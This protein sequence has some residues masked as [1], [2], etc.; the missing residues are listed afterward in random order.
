M[1]QT[2]QFATETTI[3][4]T[5][6]DSNGCTGTASTEITEEPSLSPS[7]LGDLIICEGQSTILDAGSAFDTW[8]WSTGEMT[9]T[10]EVSDAGVYSVFVTQGACSG[11]GEV[12]VIVNPLPSPS[13][14]GPTEICVGDIGTLEVLETFSIYSWSTNS[15]LQSIIVSDP[16]LYTVTVTDINGCSGTSSYEVMEVPLPTPEI[17]GDPNFCPNES[18]I[19]ELSESYE[20]YEW[21][22]GSDDE[23]ISVSMTGQYTVTVTDI[24]GCSGN[25]AINVF[26][27]PEVT[28]SIGGS[29]TYCPGGN[30]TLDGGSQYISWLWN[31][32][33]TTQT[34]QFAMEETVTLEVTDINGCV[35]TASVNITEEPSLSPTILGD[36]DICEG[37]TTI[38]DGGAAFDT[39]EWSTGETTQ[40]IEVNTSGVYTLFV[41]QGTCSGSG[42]I[43]VTVNPLPNAEIEGN[44]TICID[45]IGNLMVTDNFEQYSWSTGASL[46]SV[47]ISDPGIYTVTVTDINGCTN[48]SS[49]EVLEVSLPTP[50][51]DGDPNFCIDGSTTLGLT[52]AFAAYNWSTGST[53]AMIDVNTTGQYMVT[54]TDINGCEGSTSVNVFTYPEVEPIIGGSTSYCPGG[55]TTLDGGSQYIAWEWSTGETTQTIEFNQEATVSLQV[56]DINGCTG[57]SSVEITE[58]DSLSPS[59]I[60]DL[61]ICEGESTILD[62]GAAFDTWEWST[63]ETTQTI[64]VT[65]SGT[66]SLEVTQGACSGEGEV[67]VIV[68]PLPDPL[69]DGP[70]SICYGEDATLTSINEYEA[71][72]WTTG[73]ITRSVDI[74]NP[75]SYSLIVTDENGCTAA[76]N[77]EVIAKPTPILTDIIAICGEDKD[78]YDVTFST[79]ADEVSCDTYPVESLGTFDYAVNAI[80]TN[81]VIQIYLLDTESMCDTTITIEK[82]NCSCSAIADA[83][84]DGE[85]NCLIEQIVLGG[86]NTSEGPSFTYEWRDEDG[87]LVSTDAQYTATE[88]GTY[89]LEVF[90]SDFDC[91]VSSRYIWITSLVSIAFTA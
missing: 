42:E 12:E 67:T 66:Y 83:G 59:I 43:E 52:E 60:G 51:I 75:G 88:D 86:A 3:S 27:Y 24:N 90:D 61:D 80:D 85:L 65:T 44:E 63:G 36:V 32:G 91:S 19:L 37:E 21:S 81:D 89:T 47:F 39:W 23:S 4:L 10:I 14:S 41:T 40:T 82:P 77:F 25:T 87:N 76:T 73:D 26:M 1:T 6:T 62:G 54:V 2:I 33:E 8:E 53:D 35:G 45:A 30:T 69:I 34:I 28:P 70:E 13:I 49:V 72:Q 16:G 18:T 29:T 58:E 5:V 46:Q 31:T 57:D 11:S 7:I 68:N 50:E 22:T 64:E 17:E 9:Q 48:S 79:T 71:Y 78:T 15:N 20:T 38:L 84:P 55:T 74:S 56:T